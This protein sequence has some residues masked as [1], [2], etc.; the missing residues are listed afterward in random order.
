[1]FTGCN[2]VRH[3]FATF[4]M[5]GCVGSVAGMIALA[6]Y[7][8]DEYRYGKHSDF[9]SFISIFSVYTRGCEKLKCAVWAL[10]RAWSHSPWTPTTSIGMYI[11][12]K[13]SL[14]FSLF[15]LLFSMVCYKLKCAVWALW[16]AWS[17]SPCTLTTSIVMCVTLQIFSFISIFL[18]SENLF[19]FSLFFTVHFQLCFRLCSFW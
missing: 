11:T 13:L 10:W 7:A 4:F 19:I 6:M 16:P 8:D 15:F 18:H 2:D 1:M 3:T 9:H 14:L 12:E 5:P 17:H